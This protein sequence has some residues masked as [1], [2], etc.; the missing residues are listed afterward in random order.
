MRMMFWT[1]LRMSLS[2]HKFSIWFSLLSIRLK[3]TGK[4]LG[5]TTEASARYS[6]KILVSLSSVAFLASVAKTVSRRACIL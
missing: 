4:T 5:K 2:W 1:E 6:Y 3:M